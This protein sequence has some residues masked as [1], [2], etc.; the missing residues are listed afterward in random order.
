MVDTT[1]PGY[2]RGK[3]LKK[4]GLKGQDTS[5]LFFEDMRVP[6]S[7]ILGGED[8]LNQG[9]SFLMQELARFLFIFLFMI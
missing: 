1:T 5:E 9:F 6:A 2:S 3:L 4:V 7:A 8:G